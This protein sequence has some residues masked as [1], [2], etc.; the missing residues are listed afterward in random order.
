MEG[1]LGY[2]DFSYESKIEEMKEAKRAQG[3]RE[4]LLYSLGS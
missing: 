4:G 2:Q 3:N 1:T